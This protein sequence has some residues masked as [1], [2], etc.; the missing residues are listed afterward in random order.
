MAL[1][2]N[3]NFSIFFLPPVEHSQVQVFGPFRYD[4]HGGHQPL[5]MDEDDLQRVH[6]RDCP[7]QG[8]QGSRSL[9]GLHDTA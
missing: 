2:L 7:L 6:Q 9:R 5:R 8:R 4:A 1:L 3:S